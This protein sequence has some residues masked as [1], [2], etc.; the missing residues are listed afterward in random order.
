MLKE[1]TKTTEDFQ[2]DE[3]CLED[4]SQALYISD[5]SKKIKVQEL[6]EKHNIDE[7]KVTLKLDLYVLP[8]FMLVYFLGFLTRS[9]LG[10]LQI[11]GIYPALSISKLQFFSAYTAFFAPYIVFQFFSNIMLQRVRPHFWIS[12]SV[13]LYGSITLA[14]GYVRSYAAFIVCQFLHGFFQAGVETALFYILAHYYEKRES[15]RR[16][17]AIYSIGCI[18]GAVGTSIAFSIDK[19]LSGVH[20]LTNWQWLLIIEGAITMVASIILFV[21]IPDFPESARFLN[22]DETS[23]LIKKLELYQGKSGFELEVSFAEFKSMLTDPVIY[24]PAFASLG[25]CYATYC[26]AFFEPFYI[27]KIHN[28][29]T[30]DSNMM[31]VFPWI[32]AF[33]YSNFQSFLSDY[34]QMRY[35]FLIANVI[36]TIIGGSM[37]YSPNHVAF[38][39]HLKYGGCFLI[40]C[41]AYS[42]APLLICWTS[43][44]L[45]GHSRKNL[46]IT[47][48]VS[49]GSLGGL[50]TIYPFYN[51]AHKYAEGFLTG[52][53]FYVI[54]LLAATGYFF[55]LKKENKKKRT[56]QYKSSFAENSARKQIILGDKNPAFD[57]MY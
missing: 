2:I 31:S 33:F 13:L 54:G 45:G 25:I 10:I 37:A 12:I 15:Q 29:S 9:N 55:V 8:P 26:Y 46:G 7:K 11:E 57:Y 47:M 39:D 30:A 23:F 6:A 17:S 56:N 21:T 32:A 50:I 48:S 51:N 38:P 3:E 19:H 53:V 28:K 1:I 35:P 5:K 52:F 42:C 41:G 36:V 20:G 22:D 34:F 18:A 40:A 43:T 4:I 27:L 49:F 24:L 44:N 14:T 16:F